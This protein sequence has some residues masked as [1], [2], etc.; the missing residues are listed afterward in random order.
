MMLRQIQP[1]RMAPQPHTNDAEL[2]PLLVSCSFSE[3]QRFESIISECVATGDHCAECQQLA[4]Y[5]KSFR[6]RPHLVHLSWNGVSVINPM[7]LGDFLRVVATFA[8]RVECESPSP[9]DQHQRIVAAVV[10]FQTEQ[11]SAARS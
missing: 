8:K 5:V 1:M 6:K 7:A 9:N 2:P 10:Q 3:F 4:Q 11:N